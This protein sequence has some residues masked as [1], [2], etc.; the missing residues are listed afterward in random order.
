MCELLGLSSHH[1]T[2]INLSLTV[3]S[4][5]G[6][7]PNMHGD[8]WGVAFHEGND[9]RLIKDAGAAKNSP[10]VEFIK[11][12]SIRSHD[13]IAHIRKS[14]IGKVSYS[15]THPFIRELRGRVHSFA[16]NGTLRKIWDDERFKPI[17]Y[18][19]IGQTDSE[20]AFCVLMDRLKKIWTTGGVIPPVGDRLK[21]IKQ[22]ADDIRS[23]GPGNFLYS[24]G[25]AFFAHG[26]ERHDPLTHTL[27]WPG[28]NYIQ[29]VCNRDDKKQFE[30]VLTVDSHDDVV[31]LFASVPLNDHEN[32]RP[33]Q[34]GE[35]IAVSRGHIISSQNG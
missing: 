23:L 27:S 25:E 6:E 9:V 34:K 20:L 8:G 19:P 32:W 12:Q 30:K 11:L 28:L 31:T 1:E 24:D 21:V 18:H 33:L 14:T 26:D 4:M 17:D 16:H 5:R 7:N 10:W 3:L 22:F 13:I 2:T 35:V 29:L 15:N